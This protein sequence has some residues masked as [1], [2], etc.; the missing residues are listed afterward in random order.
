[1]NPQELAKYVETINSSTGGELIDALNGGKY[2]VSPLLDPKFLPPGLKRLCVASSNSLKDEYYKLPTGPALDKFEA[3]SIA[4]LQGYIESIVEDE[5]ERNNPLILQGPPGSGK[6]TFIRNLA[7]SIT[8]VTNGSVFFRHI[9]ASQINTNLMTAP[10]SITG[11]Y[12]RIAHRFNNGVIH[13]ETEKFLLEKCDDDPDYA[14]HLKLTELSMTDMTKLRAL[15]GSH[16]G[17]IFPEVSKDPKN[18]SQSRAEWQKDH[19][20]GKPELSVIACSLLTHHNLVVYIFIDDIGH[21]PDDR[22]QVLSSFI[23][24]MGNSTS[25]TGSPFPDNTPGSY[26]QHLMLSGKCNQRRLLA[27]AGN[28]TSSDNPLID[29]LRSRT[30][31]GTVHLPKNIT[32]TT[33]KAAVLTPALK[34]TFAHNINGRTGD[35]KEFIK[36]P[37]EHKLRGLLS[38]TTP[39]M[40]DNLLTAVFQLQ[41]H[42]TESIEKA[43][44]SDQLYALYGNRLDTLKEGIDEGYGNTLSIRQMQNAIDDISRLSSSMTGN[45]LEKCILYAFANNIFDKKAADQLMDNPSIKSIFGDLKLSS[46]NTFLDSVKDFVKSVKYEGVL[47]QK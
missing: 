19:W 47:P 6:T 43:S 25:N 8:N 22:Q 16:D 31:S 20:I 13:P 36:N 7:K 44:N 3:Q 40:L 5:G 24:F 10:M 26:L 9:T 41:N 37:N 34:R 23:G 4:K 28:E 18:I 2:D 12:D 33:Y 15:L 29:M 35:I 30:L 17:L 1:M 21:L 46:G 11:G 32:A 38:K 14:R 45:K 39:P 42:I 27:L